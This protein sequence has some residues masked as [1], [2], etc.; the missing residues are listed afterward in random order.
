VGGAAGLNYAEAVAALAAALRFGVHPSLEGIRTLAAALGNPQN[1]Y[2]CIQV[3]GT[4]GKT[5]VT[6]MTA[7]VLGA[8]GERVGTYTSPHLENYAERI[9]IG[10]EPVSE[11]DFAE[12]VAAALRASDAVLRSHHEQPG[13]AHLPLPE[14]T[15]FELLT[16]AALWRFREEGVAWAVL[17]VGM[18]GRW[19]ATSVVSP[20]VSVV[21]GV[22]LDHTDRLGSTRE[23]IAEDKSY[24]I[25]PGSVAV[26]GP[27]C[28]G[29]E[30]IFLERA[31]A[32]GVPTVRVG[33]AEDDVT[34]RVTVPASAPG[35]VTHFSVDG[36]LERYDALTI[37]APA[38]QVPNAATAIAAAEAA[39][40][41]P[42][43]ETAVR[44]ALASLTFPGRFERLRVSPPLVIDGAHNPQAAALLAE[45]INETF[46]DARPTI[47]IG[48]LADKDAEGIVRALAPVARRF[49]V[50]R[51]TNPRALPAPTLAD[52]VESVTGQAPEQT[53][54]VAAALDAVAVEPAVVT[55][56]LYVAGEARSVLR[57]RP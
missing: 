44:E 39:L 45:T 37:T 22:G 34:W 32:M 28:A 7:A 33:Q 51:A 13:S 40:G 2:R 9:A 56:S 11:A 17:E 18:G 53:D 10:T 46:G 27:G 8:H 20:S 24:V 3:T 54:S 25:K 12:A 47:V 42:L 36:A 35:G 48:V 23:E 21:T 38:C 50:T 55:G 14:F 16:A 29:I 4:N 52:V 15:E 30:H 43:D 49:V 57:A 6:R 41:V 26:L 5:S 1:A 19:D 31:I